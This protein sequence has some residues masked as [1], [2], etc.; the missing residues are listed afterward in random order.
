MRLMLIIHPHCSMHIK[1]SSV[2]SYF[3]TSLVFFLSSFILFV[4]FGFIHV[5]SCISFSV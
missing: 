2:Y 1:L 4:Q 3:F 5:F